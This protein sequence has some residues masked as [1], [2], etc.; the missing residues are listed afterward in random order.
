MAGSRGDTLVYVDLVTGQTVDSLPLPGIAAT[1][2]QPDTGEIVVLTTAS[3]D[4]TRTPALSAYGFAGS[5]LRQRNLFLKIASP[6]TNTLLA[7]D[8]SVYTADREGRIYVQSP[9]DYRPAVFSSNIL[10]SI[11][12]IAAGDEIILTNRSSV[13][14]V[15]SDFLYSTDPEAVPEYVE[16]EIAE[17]P[18]G[19]ATGIA[20][21]SSD[22]FLLY[23]KGGDYGAYV[24]F[25][26]SQS[27]STGM[28]TTTSSR[29]LGLEVSGDRLLTLDMGGEIRTTDIVT[30]EIL[31]TYTSFGLRTTKFADSDTI[32]AG[33]NRSARWNSTLLQ[34]NPNTGETVPIADTNVVTYDLSYD[35]VTRQLYT[36]GIEEIQ[37][38]LRTVLKA[39]YGR[40]FDRSRSLLSVLGEDLDASMV[41]GKDGTVYTS[42]GN[43]GVRSI[44]W[45]EALEFEDD[46]KLRRRL[47]LNRDWLIALNFDNSLTVWDTVSRKRILDFYVFADLTWAVVTSAG[48]YYTNSTVTDRILFYRGN[49]L[50]ER[51]PDSFQE[52][53]PDP[54]IVDPYFM[55]GF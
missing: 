39:H 25:T 5:N 23:T 20:P 22:E 29:Y 49:D 13:M 33:S 51:V 34:L 10:L 19:T 43:R 4:G 15:S 14:S 40:S 45:G 50:I 16:F 42:L 44:Q 3:S 1:S 6:E 27:L 28:S 12:D 46:G 11:D 8:G 47:D 41:V 24:R 2:I 38:K 31:F 21:R 35:P 48:G 32:I 52:T 7:R 54:P 53:E 36:M 18:L 30:G 37:G 26:P 55:Y 9:S 17:N